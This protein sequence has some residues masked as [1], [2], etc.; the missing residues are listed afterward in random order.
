[1][2]AANPL[3]GNITEFASRHGITALKFYLLSIARSLDADPR[4]RICHRYKLPQAESVDL[5][6]YTQP[7]SGKRVAG[8]RGTM[9]CSRFWQCPLCSTRIGTHRRD[10]LRTAINNHPD[11]IRIM[12]TYT[13]QH[14]ANTP[15]QTTLDGLLAA[16]RKLRSGRWWQ[17]IKSEFG[18]VGGVRATEITYGTAGWH[19]HFHELIF[20]APG[21]IE[22]EEI[23]IEEIS[24][25]LQALFAGRWREVLQG[26][27]LDASHEHGIDVSTKTADIA[28]YINKFARM[29]QETESW[30]ESS[31]ITLSPVKTASRGSQT[32]FEILFLARNSPQHA[33]LWAEYVQATKG[34][35]A[36]IWS[37]GTKA[38]LGIDEIRDQDVLDDTES[39]PVMII[40]RFTADQWDQLWKLGAIPAL[41]SA[42][43]AQSFERVWAIVDKV[44]AALNTPDPALCKRHSIPLKPGEKCPICE[45]DHLY[46][47]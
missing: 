6:E 41:L 13:A 26:Q 34:K 7:E 1:M 2:S 12:V 30:G 32:P 37:R 29:P 38:M 25:A 18:L 14:T 40:H 22:R 21:A 43:K 46:A 36:L 9:K 17:S 19:P 44:E 4:L 16:Y 23:S 33:A 28:A 47:R 42:A 39:Q 8:I 45:M 3:L 35:A 24:E 15:L 27:G 11:L 10:E 20:I 31:E 5:V